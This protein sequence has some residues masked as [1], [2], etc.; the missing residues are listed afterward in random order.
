MPINEWD[1]SINGW[2]P[3]RPIG[4]DADMHLP[5]CVYGP[6]ITWESATEERYC[7]DSGRPVQLIAGDRC[8]SHGARD[9]M[10]TTAL[11]APRCPHPRLSANHPY[12]KCEECGRRGQGD[13]DSSPYPS[14]GEP[15]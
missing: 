9:V 8:L 1:D 13:S 14:C 12:P 15:A 7:V 2:A 11:R 3:C 4:C 5:G 10:C 6:E